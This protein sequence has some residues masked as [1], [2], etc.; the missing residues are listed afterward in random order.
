MFSPTVGPSTISSIDSPSMTAEL[1]FLKE[2]ESL[3]LA[4]ELRCRK[5]FQR[6]KP[7]ECRFGEEIRNYLAQ[8]EN[9]TSLAHSRLP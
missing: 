6:A 2:M 9:L 1:A 3:F 4:H 7:G 8:K 5:W